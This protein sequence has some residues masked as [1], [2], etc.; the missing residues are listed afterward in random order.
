MDPPFAVTELSETYA[1]VVESR[2]FVGSPTPIA[3]PVNPA[4]IETDSTFAVA[5]ELSWAPTATELDAV[6][7]ESILNGARRGPRL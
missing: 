2:V 4:A 3:R 7:L 6:T 1:V 5:L